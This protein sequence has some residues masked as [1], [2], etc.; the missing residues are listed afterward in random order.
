MDNPNR[1][2]NIALSQTVGRQ[3]PKDDFGSILVRGAGSAISGAAQLAR[4]VG[5]NNSV[6]TA[7]ASVVEASVS[8]VVGH[9]AG[10]ASSGIA[11]QAR[12]A[13]AGAV[14]GA[15]AG[16][17][18]ATGKGEQWDLLDAQKALNA[19]GQAFNA[20]YLQLQNAMQKESREFQA[21]SNIMKVRHD[22]AKAAINNIR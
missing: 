2:A 18:G 22:S 14:G 11:V 7:A 17:A 16:V 4:V 6:V 13:V 1:I 3:T 9:V 21:V 5:G 10:G 20:A 12:G 19:E 8:A 15:T